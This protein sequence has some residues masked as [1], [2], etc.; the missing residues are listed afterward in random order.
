MTSGSAMVLYNGSIL[1]FIHSW[2]LTL[3]S[4]TGNSRYNKNPAN[5]IILKQEQI[6]RII[7]WLLYLG[8]RSVL[9][10]NQ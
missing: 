6:D 9:T 1:V 7:P 2:T 3:K 5:Y 10:S 4:T 8:Q